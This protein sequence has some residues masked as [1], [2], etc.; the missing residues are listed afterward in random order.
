M[1]S[2]FL[3][4]AISAKKEKNILFKVLLKSFLSFKLQKGR[5]IPSKLFSYLLG[6]LHNCFIIFCAIAFMCGCTNEDSGVLKKDFKEKIT[7]AKNYSCNAKITAISNK[8]EDVY[9]VFLIWEDSGK[10]KIKTSKPEILSGNIILFDGK[11]LWQYN[12][13]VQSKISFSGVGGNFDG[14][15]KIFISEFMKSYLNSRGISEKDVFLNGKSYHIYDADIDGG[16][17]FSEQKLWVDMEDSVPFKLETFDSE[18]NI[19]F[20]AEFSDFKFDAELSE[21][22]FTGFQ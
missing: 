13:N 16:K 10:Y 19:V 18:G 17:Y 3:F 5:K 4:S 20:T 12:P 1:K 21:D 22:E 6:V 14:K 11:G 7:S 8:N 15:S 9:E 2:F